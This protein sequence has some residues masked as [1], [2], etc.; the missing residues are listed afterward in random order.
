MPMKLTDA[1]AAPEAAAEA[2]ELLEQAADAIEASP[3]LNVLDAWRQLTEGE[4]AGRRDRVVGN[5]Y[6]LLLDYLPLGTESLA[7]WSDA[8]TSDRVAIKLRQ[9]GRTLRRGGPAKIEDQSVPAGLAAEPEPEEPAPVV[10]NRKGRHK[11]ERRAGHAKQDRPPKSELA[12]LRHQRGITAG[13]ITRQK[14]AKH[15]QGAK[16]TE[17]E[18]LL[19]ELDRRIAQLVLEEAAEGSSSSSEAGEEGEAGEPRDADT[20]LV[21]AGSAARNGSAGSWSGL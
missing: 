8:E 11:H 17:N 2:A 12:R 1:A 21:A 13:A 5:A 19:V 6:Y 14:R 20:E 9:L 3:G 4:P 18:L 16:L 15:P 10:G 7:H